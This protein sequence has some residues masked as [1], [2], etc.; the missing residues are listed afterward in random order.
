[1]C[2]CLFRW[3]VGILIFEMLAGYPPFFSTN[4]FS[5]YQKILECKIKFPNTLDRRARSV[6]TE[7]LSLDRGS[8]LGCTMGGFGSIT[9]HSFYSGISWDSAKQALLQ[10]LL[11]PTVLSAGDTSNFD[12]YAEEDSEVSSNLKAEEREMFKEFDP[13]LNR[14][15]K[16]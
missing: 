5:V 10:P 9:R 14:P 11:V 2:V 12:F 6:V 7:F 4:P 8:R 15:V 3:A 13:I 1:M 16:I